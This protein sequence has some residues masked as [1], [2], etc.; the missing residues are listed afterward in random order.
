MEDTLITKIYLSNF[1]LTFYLIFVAVKFN[2]KL[3][4][5]F[6]SLIIKSVDNGADSDSP[7]K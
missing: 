3:G 2:Y 5:K 7:R 1:K 6:Q 4:I